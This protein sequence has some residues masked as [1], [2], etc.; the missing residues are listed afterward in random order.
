MT[1]IKKGYSDFKRYGK[2]YLVNINVPL[3]LTVFIKSNFFVETFNVGLKSI[4]EALLTIIS[5]LPNFYAILL[6]EFLT[7]YSFLKSHDKGNT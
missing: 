2:Q 5:I 1:F 7:S 4:A 6:T 3:V